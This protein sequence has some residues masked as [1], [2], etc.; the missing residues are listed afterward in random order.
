MPPTEDTEIPA[1]GWAFVLCFLVA[2][3]LVI[4]ANIWLY[5]M[6]E[7]VNRRLPK[8]AKIEFVGRWKMYK[9]LSLHSEMFPKIPKR[10]QM[11]TLAL[12]GFA[13]LFG[14]FFAS[15]ILNSH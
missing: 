4:A 12:I 3:T 8:E 1:S 13:F 9:V 14:G 15:A 6:L 5:W 7:E 10:W 2:I 11:W